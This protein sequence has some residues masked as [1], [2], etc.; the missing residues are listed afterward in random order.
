MVNKQQNY[1]S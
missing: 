1:R